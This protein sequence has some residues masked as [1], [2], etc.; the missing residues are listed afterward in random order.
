MPFFPVTNSPWRKTTPL[1]EEIALDPELLGKVFENLL[2]SYNEDTRTTARKA[3]GAFYTP[4]EIVAYMVDE[5]LR[6]HLGAAAPNLA[7]AQLAALFARR[8]HAAAG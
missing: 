6:A 5:T 2:A 7:P 4:R 8:R 3:T 1:E